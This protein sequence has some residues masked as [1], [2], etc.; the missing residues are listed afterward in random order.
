MSLNDRKLN[1]VS[2][3]EWIKRSP[4]GKTAVIY[5]DKALELK[6]SVQNSPVSKAFPTVA[7]W[8]LLVF[9]YAISLAIFGTVQKAGIIEVQYEINNTKA[10][11]Y[12]LEHEK[13]KVAVDIQRL[14]SL[15]RIASEAGK[16]N[17]VYPQVKVLEAKK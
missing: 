8:T 1:T 14:S 10:A 6:T 4:I 17:M 9:A 11:Y 7:V 3:P 13:Q 15:E 16:L 2:I 5:E 12:D